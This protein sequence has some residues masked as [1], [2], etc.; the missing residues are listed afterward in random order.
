M[1]TRQVKT[2][3][4]IFALAFLAL[5]QTGAQAAETPASERE[6]D[7]ASVGESE[8]SNLEIPAISLVGMIPAEGRLGA[9]MHQFRERHPRY[10]AQSQRARSARMLRRA[11]ADQFYSPVL[12]ASAGRTENPT[13]APRT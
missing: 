9:W 3:S 2:A 7:R 6:K 11:A 1:N 12:T 8:I 5:V 13:E 10:L 4:E